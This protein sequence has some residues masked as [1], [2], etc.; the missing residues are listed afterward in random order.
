MLS[1]RSDY[2]AHLGLVAIEAVREPSRCDTMEAVINVDGKDCLADTTHRAPGAS[3]DEAGKH[4]AAP[5]TY[6]PGRNGGPPDCLPEA[7]HRCFAWRHS[8]MMFNW[9]DV[10]R[11]Q[12]TWI[13]FLQVLR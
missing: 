6:D 13:I 2:C 4:W 11:K 3:G 5:D 8:S 10:K 9:S 7:I 1:H 12:S